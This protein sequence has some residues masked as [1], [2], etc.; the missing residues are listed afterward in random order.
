[1]RLIMFLT[2]VTLGVCPTS[3][4]IS[5]QRSFI[6]MTISKHS[7]VKA[8]CIINSNIINCSSVCQVHKLNKEEKCSG[9]HSQSGNLKH[10]VFKCLFIELVYLYPSLRSKYSNTCSMTCFRWAQAL[11]HYIWIAE[12]KWKASQTDCILL[13]RQVKQN[14]IYQCVSIKKYKVVYIY[15][16][17]Y[18]I[19]IPLT[20][21]LSVC[22]EMM[23]VII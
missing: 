7:V 11:F 5:I 15:M 18:F 9:E 12:W 17:I 19:H 4:L 2:A 6:G 16:Y 23:F 22:L 1:M 10:C 14:S 20:S 13:I 3:T 8:H 21:Y